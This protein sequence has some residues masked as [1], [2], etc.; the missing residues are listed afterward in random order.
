MQPTSY[1]KSPA[2]EKIV[3]DLYDRLLANWPVPMKRA[4]SIPARQ[5]LYDRLR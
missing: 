5:D 2:S 1:F 3:M 4:I